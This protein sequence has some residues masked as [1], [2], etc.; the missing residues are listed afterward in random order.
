M[1][2]QSG[3]AS[4]K[5]SESRLRKRQC[6]LFFIFVFVISIVFLFSLYVNQAAG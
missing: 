5:G 6:A 3:I 2:N 1:A 4:R